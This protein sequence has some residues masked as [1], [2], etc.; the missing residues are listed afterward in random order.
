[1]TK[2]T[3]NTYFIWKNLHKFNKSAPKS[4]KTTFAILF[5]I[6]IL[7]F[8][9]LSPL[10]PFKRKLKSCRAFLSSNNI[11][12]QTKTFQQYLQIELFTLQRLWNVNNHIES[13]LSR[14]PSISVDKSARLSCTF[15]EE[16]LCVRSQKGIFFL[17]NFPFPSF[18]VEMSDKNWWQN[19]IDCS[20]LAHRFVWSS[21]F[22]AK[23]IRSIKMR[24]RW[25]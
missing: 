22:I 7:F 12:W 24:G 13:M 11:F 3:F 8:F 9:T 21:R 2:K 20:P 17:F 1:M 5:R 6:L 19:S 16:I 4:T 10:K 14:F 15:V 25:T 23:F 18:Y